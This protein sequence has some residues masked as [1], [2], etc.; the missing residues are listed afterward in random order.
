VIVNDLIEALTISD[1]ARIKG[2]RDAIAAHP[3]PWQI[4]LS[5]FPAV[6]RVLNPPFINPHLPKMYGVCR[7]FIPYLSKRGIASLIYLELM[8]YARRPKLETLPP[9]PRPDR[10]VAFEEIEKSIAQND[11]DGTARLLDAF[12]VHQGPGELMR[13]LLL[14]GSGYLEKSL[15]H[16]ISCTAFILL[17]LLHRDATEA[18]PALVLLA[19]Y[20]CKGGF[21]TTPELIRYS[22]TSP[23]H[24]LL[25]RSVTGSGFVDIHHTITLYAIERSRSF[26]SD[27][28]HGHLIAAWAA[29]LGTKPSR[30]R[31]FPR[32][33]TQAAAIDTTIAEYGDF[34]HSFLQL[35]A[36][37]MLAQ[38]GG[39]IEESDARTR[40]CSFLIQSVCDLYDGNYN[41]HYLTGLGALMWALNTHHQEVGL[42]QNALYQ[43]LDFYFSAMRS[44]R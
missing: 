2:M 13:R 20:F 27:Q 25:F 3:D 41:P 1:T 15:G 29:W 11:R 8:E 14:L 4:H 19:D 37:R 24:D 40:L 17:E 36:D 38:I 30:P 34:T 28:E 23:S 31:S 44:K 21:H 12:L 42:V 32:D 18:W 5:L 43:Y 7:D 33:K 22:P 10:P 35:D 26:S 6:Q 9:P 16:S 39:M